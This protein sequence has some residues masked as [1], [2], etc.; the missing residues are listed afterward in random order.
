MRFNKN[1]WLAI[2]LIGAISINTLTHLFHPAI[3]HYR[4]TANDLRS[5]YTNF[6]VRVQ[7]DFVPT[8]YTAVT[9]RPSIVYNVV[10]SNGAERVSS[11]SSTRTFVRSTVDYQYAIVEGRPC[12]MINGWR[13]CLGDTFQGSPVVNMRP[14]MF[15]TANGNIFVNRNFVVRSSTGVENE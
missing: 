3:K 4:E 1:Q 11:A 5:Q 9:N 2:L 12:L 13:Y 14:D 8:I 7:R 10:G 6:V 15:L